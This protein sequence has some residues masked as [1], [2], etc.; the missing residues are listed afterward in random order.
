MH[1][2]NEPVGK[3]GEIRPHY[4]A[5]FAHWN[6]LP[7]QKHRALHSRS[8]GWQVDCSMLGS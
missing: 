1:Y 7:P 5:I 8:R 4:A 6:S 2:F 3:D